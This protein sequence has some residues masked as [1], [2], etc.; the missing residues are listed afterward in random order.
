MLHK[1]LMKKTESDGEVEGSFSNMFTLFGKIL[2]IFLLREHISNSNQITI[3][4]WITYIRKFCMDRIGPL[5][6]SVYRAVNR[7]NNFSESGHRTLN[8]CMHG[9]HI[10]YYEFIKE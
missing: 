7:T 1:W 2:M 6:F 4:Q 3:G 5:R 10:N 9:K 8:E